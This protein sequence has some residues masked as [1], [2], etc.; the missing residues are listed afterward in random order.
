MGPRNAG[1]CRRGLTWATA[2]GGRLLPIVCIATST[3]SN[4]YPRRSTDT[5]NRFPWGRR[6]LAATLSRARELHV[7]ER[8]SGAQ[9]NGIDYSIVNPKHLSSGLQASICA[10]CHLQGE[11][12][13]NRR[14]RSLFEF[15]P[16]CRWRRSSRCLSAIPMPW[17]FAGR[18]AS[19]TIACQPLLHRQ[20][21]PAR[22][23][24]VPRSPQSPGAG[25]TRCILQPEMS[26]MPRSGCKRM[27]GTPG[28]PTSEKRSLRRLSHASIGK[29]QYRAHQHHRPSHSAAAER[30]DAISW[31][32]AGHHPH[33]PVPDWPARPFKRRSGAH[34]WE[35]GL[36]TSFTTCR[37]R[38]GGFSL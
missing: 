22:L 12:K 16:G 33:R 36:R 29:L 32:D 5:W 28:R 18:S 19:S 23:H 24:V 7:A 13:V 35:L 38:K 15:R 14:G 8:M 4:R 6:R 11:Q 34:R 9:V 26:S 3:G 30:R 2:A 17:T 27:F 37:P 1:T 31:S 21:W 25:E 10:Q 20:Q